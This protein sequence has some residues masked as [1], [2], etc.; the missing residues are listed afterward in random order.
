[1]ANRYAGQTADTTS[2]PGTLSPENGAM[3]ATD[4]RK[5]QK[6][7]ARKKS[8]RKAKHASVARTGGS[9]TLIQA[10]ARAPVERCL[11]PQELFESGMGSIFLSRR[12]GDGNLVTAAY[13]VDTYCLGVKDAFVMNVAAHELDERLA[14]Q[15]Q[16]YVDIPVACARKLLH[17][18]VAF[19]RDLGIPPHSDYAKFEKLFGDADPAACEQ[20]FEY[21]RDGQ[22]LYIP[23]PNDSPKLMQRVARALEND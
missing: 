4:P 11:M 2:D 8:K 16:T 13:L 22:P 12:L 7:L 23:G 9:A 1:M 17:G 5:R 21:G 15:P 10:A 18:A 6:Q 3:M 19:A 20:V 14:M